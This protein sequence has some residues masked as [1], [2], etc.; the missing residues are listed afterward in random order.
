[1]GVDKR[2]RKREGRRERKREKRNS[3]RALDEGEARLIDEIDNLVGE[4]RRDDEDGPG[5]SEEKQR[6][7]PR[8]SG[9]ICMHAW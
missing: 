7:E 3:N 4:T 9:P 1:M 2:R 5:G 6:R 8:L